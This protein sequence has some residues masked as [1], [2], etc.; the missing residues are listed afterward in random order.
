MGGKTTNNIMVSYYRA[1]DRGPERV[2]R[3]SLTYRNTQA[4]DPADPPKCNPTATWKLDPVL[5]FS[6]LTA[7]L[8]PVFCDLLLAT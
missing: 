6:L 3:S 2:V 8:I 1:G 5:W 7:C 4:R